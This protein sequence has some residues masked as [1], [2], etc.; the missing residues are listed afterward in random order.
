MTD[1]KRLLE[2]LTKQ[3]FLKWKLKMVISS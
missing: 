3:S 1:D 2:N